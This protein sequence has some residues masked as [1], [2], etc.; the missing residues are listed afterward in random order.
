LVYVDLSNNTSTEQKRKILL[1]RKQYYL[2]SIN[3]SLNTCKRD[4]YPLGVKRDITFSVNLSMSRRGK[5]KKLNTRVNKI[6]S[7]TKVVTSETK[8]L[9][10]SRC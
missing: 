6:Y 1:L 5:S 7:I 3:P 4:D 9:I 10:S 8:L 2:D